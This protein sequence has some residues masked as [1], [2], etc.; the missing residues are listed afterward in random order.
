ML[1]ILFH[2][3]NSLIKFESKQTML[4]F[5]S[6]SESFYTT[7]KQWEVDLEKTVIGADK[8]IT[9]FIC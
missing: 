8:K 6:K 9:S 2:L 1:H 3:F 5:F 7:T 4:I